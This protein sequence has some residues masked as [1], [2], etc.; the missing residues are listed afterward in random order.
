MKT[1][2]R[3][4]LL[5]LVLCLSGCKTKEKV[6]ERQTET[7]QASSV[8]AQIQQQQAELHGQTSLTAENT[9]TQVSDSVVERFRE[10]IVTDS[11]GHVLLHDVEHSRERYKG[12]AASQKKQTDMRDEQLTV[13]S[14]MGTLVQCD[15]TYNGGTLKEETVVKKWSWRWS[16]FVGVLASLLTAGYISSR[17]KR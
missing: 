7:T 10:R 4:L 15:S 8:T 13:K 17:V 2:I 9:Q 3:I 5:L 6:T 1:T 16:W 11:A 12:K 14:D